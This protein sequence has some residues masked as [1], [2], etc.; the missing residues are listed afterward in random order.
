[1]LK[2]GNKDLKIKYRL[3]EAAKY[4]MNDIKK[5][6][7]KSYEKN[8]ENMIIGIDFDN[9]I[10]NYTKSFIYLSRK[11]KNQNVYKTKSVPTN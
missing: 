11:K 8:Q 9:T 10:I 3:S 2:T 1:M 4:Y 6:I 5:H 7:F